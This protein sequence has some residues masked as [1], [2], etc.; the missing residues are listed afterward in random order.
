MISELKKH[1]FTEEEAEFI[2]RDYDLEAVPCDMRDPKLLAWDVIRQCATNTV[3]RTGNAKIQ[4]RY[5]HL[6]RV[7]IH[8]Y[9]LS[10]DEAE[11]LLI[12]GHVYE[13]I[14]RYPGVLEKES[15]DRIIL[16]TMK[17]IALRTAKWEV[18]E[19]KILKL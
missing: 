5:D 13:Q 15:D 8:Q 9:M 2:L 17:E 18:E 12:L 3:K 19:M 14:E 16:E 7:L 1:Y 11:R 6:K 4:Q 10:E